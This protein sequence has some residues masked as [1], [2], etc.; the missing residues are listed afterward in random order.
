[1]DKHIRKQQKKKSWPF[2]LGVIVLIFA[3]FGAYSAVRLVVGAVKSKTAAKVD[4]SAYTSYLEWVVGTDPKPFSDITKAEPSELL[5]IAI[6]SLLSSGLQTGQYAVTENGM[7]IPASDVETYFIRMFGSEVK[8]VNQTVVGYGYTFTYDEG[9]KMYTVPVTG[10]TPPFTP[11]IISVTKAGGV[12]TLLVGYVGT[13]NVEVGSDGTLT[14]AQ[15]DKYMKITL[16]AT[17][18]G[19]NLVSLSTVTQG[20]YQ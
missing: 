3:L 15:P 17:D 7:Q 19:F 11:R 20:E 13:G 14:A 10:V 5:N 4:Y 16:K 18:S 1:M 8:I 2:V 9:T 6:C 12:S